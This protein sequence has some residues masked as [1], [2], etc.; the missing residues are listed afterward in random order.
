MRLPLLR[1][2]ENVAPRNPIALK[3]FPQI[4]NFPLPR[5]GARDFRH[6]GG[7]GIDSVAD[8]THFEHVSAAVASGHNLP[9]FAKRDQNGALD[10]R[11]IL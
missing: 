11:W 2:P 4:E 10:K 1:L 7:N 5:D 6:V 8:N 3:R 9:E